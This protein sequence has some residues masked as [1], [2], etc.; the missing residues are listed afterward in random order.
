M[1]VT[2]YV[3]GFNHANL[4]ADPSCA[5]LNMTGVKKKIRVIDDWSAG[6]KSLYLTPIKAITVAAKHKLT[7]TSN[8]FGMIISEYT[9]ISGGYKRQITNMT[10]RPCK[11]TIKF[12]ITTA[13]VCSIMGLGILYMIDFSRVKQPADSRMHDDRN[14]QIIRPI[15]SRGMKVCLSWWEIM[16]QT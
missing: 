4:A 2:R 11:N 14:C 7:S 12:R 16:L 6:S 5:G 9:V 13:T 8:M 1:S 3:N 15:Q 10:V